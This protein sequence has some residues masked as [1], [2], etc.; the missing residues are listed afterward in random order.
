MKNLEKVRTR[1]NQAIIS[2]CN[3]ETILSISRELDELIVLR[4]RAQN[5][6]Y[7]KERV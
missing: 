7:I 3:T 5:R 6:K 4:M 2:G 1:L